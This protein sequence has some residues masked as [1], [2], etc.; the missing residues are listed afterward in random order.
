MMYFDWFDSPTNL[1]C[2]QTMNLSIKESIQFDSPTNLHCSQTHHLIN[3]SL[4]VFDS[5]T[6]LHCSQTY[7]VGVQAGLCLIPLRICTALKP[8]LCRP[9]GLCV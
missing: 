2:S 3:M 5:P 7:Q 4:H 1:H 9:V 6:N 8:L